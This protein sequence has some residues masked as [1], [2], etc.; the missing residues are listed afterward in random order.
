MFGGPGG[1]D[2]TGGTLGGGGGAG[3]VNDADEPNGVGAPKGAEDILDDGIIGL[4][5]T[6]GELDDVGFGLTVVGL[7]AASIAFIFA[8]LSS[9]PANIIPDKIPVKNVEIGIKSSKNF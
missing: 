2:D 3:G 1:P 7:V 4:G 6:L 9:L 5:P 8:S